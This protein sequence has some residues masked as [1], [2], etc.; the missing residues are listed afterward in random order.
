MPWRDM[1]IDDDVS[2]LKRDYPGTARF[3]ADDDIEPFVVDALL[4]VGCKVT[5]SEQARL[6]GRDDRDHLAYAKRENLILLTKDKDYLDDRK[7]PISQCT[8]IIVFD[9]GG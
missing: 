6:R 2:D 7:H 3:Y 4:E 9:V 1:D 8:G 5:T